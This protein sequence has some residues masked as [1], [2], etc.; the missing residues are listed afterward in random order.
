[1]STYPGDR[2]ADAGQRRVPYRGVRLLQEPRF[3][4]DA[5]FTHEERLRLGLDGLLPPTPLSLK[6]QV[7][8]ELEHLRC[9]PDD[10]E[11]FIGLIALLD[12]N[13]TLFYRV[14]IDNFRELLPI[15]YTPTVG[16]ACESYS[17]IIR[18]P[19]GLWITPND[20]GR[21]PEVLRNTGRNDV[22]LIVVTDNERILGLG[23][24]GAGGMGIPVGKI[25]IYCA[26]AGIDPGLCL[27]ISLDVGTDNAKLLADP[28]Y[29]G[30]RARRLRGEEYDRFIEA[31]VDAVLEV[32]PRA[33]I[34]WEDFSRHNAFKLLDRYRK[35]TPSFNDD[36]QGT[37]AVA[38]AGIW[39]ALRITGGTLA[40]Q[41][42]MHAG[43]G[44][45]GIGIGRL[46]HFALL[47]DGVDPAKA[48]RVQSFVDTHGLVYDDRPIR[49]A[50]KAE[51]AVNATWRDEMGIQPGMSIHLLEAVKRIRPTILIGT[52]AQPGIFD[53][54]VVREMSRHCERPVIFALSNPT[55]KAECT[56]AEALKWSD[57]RALIATGSP[58]PT[59]EYGGRWHE[60]GQ[61]NNALVCPGIGFGSILAETLEVTDDMF[62]AAARTLADAVPANRL[63]QGALYPNINDL[64]AFNA[65]IAAAVIR[66]A[67]EQGVGRLI[68]DR[69]VETLV[70]EKT[71]YPEYEEY[72]S[73]EST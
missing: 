25:T 23:D 73:A 6:E 26:A 45:A 64:R 38:L 39:S 37:A 35:R 12:R 70:A 41:R 56:P 53:E 69:N 65:R 44:S 47:R 17:H 4:K 5:A 27:P 66:A 11:R 7:T 20:V 58:F 48:R 63:D 13:E 16:K 19:R 60:S 3:N 71:W 67:R 10:L 34:Q 24:Q 21:I 32:W 8:L 46:I 50:Y 51:F 52:T 2:R 68:A 18:R 9:K 72:T 29:C 55:S 57:G 28:F 54:A 59:V 31:F 49:E 42:V 1:M 43:S 33:L 62:Y 36:I 61:A 14:L 40:E 22:R 30:H 15:V